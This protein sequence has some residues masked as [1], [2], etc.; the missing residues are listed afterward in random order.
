MLRPAGRP[1][2]M[3]CGAGAAAE[4]GAVTVRPGGVAP[5]PACGSAAG[6]V[7]VEEQAASAA[8]RANGASL[9]GVSLGLR[10][11][12]AIYRAAMLFEVKKC[13][14]PVGLQPVEAAHLVVVP[15]E[16]HHQLA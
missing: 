5:W 15:L 16:A 6:S 7:G 3:S 10:L 8:A 4:F 2:D 1:R 13:A 9:I 14:E 12:P 11:Q